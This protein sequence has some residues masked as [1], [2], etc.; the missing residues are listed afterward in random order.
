[1]S[2]NSLT[3]LLWRE[4]ELL[5]LLEFKMEE[6]QLLLFAGRS[7]WINHAA[8]EIEAV[9]DKVRTASLA[10]AVESAAVATEHRLE[11]NATLA[12]IIAAV[13]E[14]AWREIMEGHLGALR[15][16]TSRISALRESSTAQLRSAQRAT[17]ET[18]ATLDVETYSGAGTT[19][20]D[21]STRTA[22]LLD[23]EA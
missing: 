20:G 2:L 17:Q 6:Q 3:A 18:L 22:G 13:K 9:L 7:Q 16:S 14:P 1:M 4:R 10:R 11:D 8:R 21:R 23:M 12:E 15:G 19:S 5:D